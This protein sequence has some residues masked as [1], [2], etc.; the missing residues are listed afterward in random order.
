L[1]VPT[2]QRLVEAAFATR[3]AIPI[4]LLLLSPRRLHLGGSQPSSHIRHFSGR[5]ADRHLIRRYA[6]IRI[7]RRQRMSIPLSIDITRDDAPH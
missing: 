1:G 2:H 7:A 6:T 3:T 4:I 5:C